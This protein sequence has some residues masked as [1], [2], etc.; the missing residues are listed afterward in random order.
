MVRNARLLASHKSLYLPAAWRLFCITRTS[1]PNPNRYLDI[2]FLYVRR[3]WRTSDAKQYS[4]PAAGRWWDIK[5]LRWWDKTFLR[6]ES[7]VPKLRIVE[8][9]RTPGN[10]TDSALFEK[11][12]YWSSRRLF[13]IISVLW[14]VENILRH[15]LNPLLDLFRLPT[16]AVESPVASSRN[17]FTRCDKSEKG[18]Y[19]IKAP[20]QIFP[21][22][23]QS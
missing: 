16:C 3:K 2:K 4:I 19:L 23:L 12:G 18:A 13:Y 22:F 21:S 20:H 10:R 6:K 17:L 5:F 9:T 1:F 11:R 15:V 7:N 14:L 8:R